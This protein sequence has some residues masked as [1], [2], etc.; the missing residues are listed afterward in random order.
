MKKYKNIR[1]IVAGILLMAPL[2]FCYGKESVI[3]IKLDERTIEDFKDINDLIYI[4]VPEATNFS[5]IH[6]VDIEIE[7][8]GVLKN[9][10]Y[11]TQLNDPLKIPFAFK[12]KVIHKTLDFVKHGEWRL[13]VPATAWQPRDGAGLLYFKNKLWLLGGWTGGPVTNEVWAS[14]DGRNWSFVTH[15]P[16]ENRHGAGWV[17]HNDELYVIGGELLDD[18]WASSDGIHWEQKIKHAPFGKRYTPNVVSF[19]GFIYLFG[20]QYWEPVD[21]CH[22]R[23]DCKA[24]GLNDVWRSK[25]GI[26]WELVTMHSPWAPRALIHGQAVLNKKFYVVGGGLKAPLPNQRYQETVIEYRDMWYTTDGKNWMRENVE[27]PA[28]GRTHF[29]VVGM[30]DDIYISGGSVG[31]QLNLSNDFYRFHNQTWTKIETPWQPRHADSMAVFHD[32]II[33]TGGMHNEVWQYFP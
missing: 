5:E 29:T 15:A 8:S 1:Q 19:N 31:I 23:P 2:I 17:V 11:T 32:S 20:G 21:W 4:Y 28:P 6:K 12:D 22:S 18:V 13:L 26:N 30:N 33:L 9:F 14:D 16:W 27:I 24:V 25:D 7:S 3:N 10:T